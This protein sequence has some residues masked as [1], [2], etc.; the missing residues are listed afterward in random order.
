MAT[1]Q[2]KIEN[3]F[4]VGSN[5]VYLDELE[6]TH[7]IGNGWDCVIKEDGTIECNAVRDYSDGE[8]SMRYV[9]MSNGYAK[10]TL[11]VSGQKPKVIRKGFVVPRG[12]KLVSG[13][14]GLAGGYID[15]RYAY[16]R[17]SSF[18]EF[19]D[20]YGITAVKHEDPNHSYVVRH[21]EYGGGYCFCN[22]TTDGTVADVGF[23]LGRS[24]EWAEEN[25]GTCASEC[26]YHKEVT[27]ATWVVVEKR[28]WEGDNKNYSKIL[29]TLADPTTLELPKKEG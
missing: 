11:K 25:P 16:F 29:Y 19:L 21:A 3:G 13:I 7:A 4:F 2:L 26:D 15:N 9:I 20:K 28:Q 1:L 10:L 5:N 14:I 12:Q 17:D 8:H 24:E 23:D 27:G 18:Q 6:P 22:L